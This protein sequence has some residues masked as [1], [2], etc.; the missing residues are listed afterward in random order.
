MSP[1]GIESFV[2]QFAWLLLGATAIGILAQRVHV[3]YA[4]ALVVAGL[5]VEASHPVRVPVLDPE[6]VL[7]ALLPPLLFDAGFRL[8]A[9]EVRLVARPVLLLAVPGSCRNR[10]DPLLATSE[11]G[12][13]RA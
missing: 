9:R 11:V 1:F 10:P 12:G 7:V 6:L 8:E 2:V 5:N 13:S 3:P 4:V